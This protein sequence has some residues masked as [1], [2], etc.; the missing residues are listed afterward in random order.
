VWR[1]CLFGHGRIVILLGGFWPWANLF[2]TLR[3][4]QINDVSNGI[5]KFY[6]GH[7][8]VV[9]FLVGCL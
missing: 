9:I 7:W 6:F 5:D 1:W 2:V 4:S 8:K 3:Q